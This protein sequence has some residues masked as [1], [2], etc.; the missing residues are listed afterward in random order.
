M[1][2]PAWFCVDRMLLRLPLLLLFVLTLSSHAGEM[3]AQSA[4]PAPASPVVVE[5][6]VPAAPAPGLRQVSARFSAPMVALGSP[7]SP[8]PFDV[9]CPVPGRGR[10]LDDRTWVYDLAAPLPGGIECRFAIRANLTARAG[11]P[12]G[13]NLRFVA[14]SGGPQIAA[15]LP[16][17]GAEAIDESQVFALRTDGAI[18]VESAVS[19]SYCEVDGIAE[20]IPVRLITGAE[21]EEILGQ[22]RALG[23]DYLR[24]LAPDG[25][26][27]ALPPVADRGA[28]EDRLLLFQCQR[29][30]PPGRPM[31]LVWG[32]GIV[33][34]TGVATTSP[35]VFG[36]ATRPAFAATLACQRIN[37]AADCLPLAPIRLEF[38]APVARAVAA[39]V[40]LVP[41]SGGSA[42]PMTLEPAFGEFVDAIEFRAPFAP[43]STLS[44]RLPAGLVDDAG[45]TLSNQDRFPL[46]V[47]L[48]ELPPLASFPSA[49]GIL[50][51]RAEPVLPVTLRNLEPTLDAARLD[52]GVPANAAAVPAERKR[53]DASDADILRWLQRVDEARATRFEPDPAAPDDPARSINATGTRSV[54]GKDDAPERFVLPKPSGAQPLEVVGIPLE[55]PGFYVV[56]L[57]SPQLGAA[58]LGRTATMYVPTAVLVTNL[59]VHFKQGDESALVF[60]TTLDSAAPVADARVRISSCSGQALWSGS[61]DADGIARVPRGALPARDA[62]QWCASTGSALFV[63]A[64]QGEELGF[65]LSSWNRGIAPWDFNL[66]TTPWTG[67]L[68]A[69]TVLDRTLVRAGDT[70]HMKHFLRRQT[71][72]GFEAVSAA[73]APT[74]LVLTHVGSGDTV[75]LPLDLVD[76]VGAGDWRVPP[77]AKLGVYRMS[78]R[79]GDKTLEAGEFRV[80]EF[81]VPTLR[82]TVQPAAT[83]LVDAREAVVDLQL[84]YMNGGPVQGAPVRLRSQ[85]ESRQVAF[86]A[87]EG[88]VFAGGDV[89]EGA[90]DERSWADRYFATA[91]TPSETRARGPARVL[92]LRLDAGG[93]VRATVTGLEPATEPRT[94]VTE[95]EY[96]DANG[97]TL[98]VAA[99]TRLWP[100]RVVLGFA[101]GNWA[102]ARGHVAFRVLAVDTGGTPIANQA[103]SVDLFARETYSYRKRL[104]GGFYAYENST[105][106]RRLPET[107]SGRTDASGVLSCDVL[108]SASGRIVARARA[109]DESGRVAVASH[110]VWVAGRDDW[111]FEAEDSDRMDVLPE[112]PRYE[113]G[114]R[115][116]LQ[117]R[118][119]FREARALVTVEREGVLD[120][121][122]TTLSGA[123]PVVEV[124]IR[125][126][127]GPNVYVS[128][129]ALRGRAA[130]PAPTALVDLGRPAFRLGYA[131]LEVGWQP[132]RLQVQV[133]S[134]QTTYET[135]ATARVHVKVAR[136]DGAPLP[137]GTEFALAAVDEALLELA[138]ND[139]YRLLE[140]MLVPR[141][142]G[143]ITATAQMQVVGK[144]HYGR[145]AEPAG[146]GGGRSAARELFDTLLL[147]RARVPVDAE[148]EADVDVRLNDALSAFRIVAIAHAGT[149]LYGTGAMT[150]RTTAPLSLLAGLPPVVREGDHFVATFTVRNATEAALPVVVQP[151]VLAAQ[152]GAATRTLPVRPAQVTLAPGEGR[153][154]RWDIDVP[155]EAAQLVWTVTATRAGAAPQAVPPG[156]RLRVTQRV[157]P[158]VPVTTQQATVFALDGATTLPVEAPA[159]ALPGRGGLTLAL[160]PR[161]VDSL[162]GLTR[163]MA[164][165]PYSCLEQR[166]S[167][168]VALKD[169]ARWRAIAADLPSYLDNDG[170]LRFFPGTAG[171]GSDVLTAYVLAIASEAGWSLPESVRERTLSALRGIVD[172]A[173][174][175][176]S[177]AA[178]PDLELR[179]IAAIEALSRYGAASPEMLQ[180][181]RIEPALLPTSSLLDLIGILS[182]VN[183]VEQRDARLRAARDLLRARQYAT[184]TVLA[185]ATE[186]DD[187]LWWL[188][189]SPDQNAVRSLLAVL[190]DPARRDQLPALVRGA[191]ARQQG[192]HWDTTL[193]NAWGRLALDRL[194]RTVDASPL[195][196]V[197]RALLAPASS[198]QDWHRAPAGSVLSM[199]W[200]GSTPAAL[201]LSHEGTGRPWVTLASSAAVPLTTSIANGYALRRTL[202]PVVQ[203]TP[204]VHTRGDVLRVTIEVESAADMAWVVV[205]DPVPAGA[206]IIGRGL[207]RDS[208]LLTAGQAEPSLA[209]DFVEPRADVYRA[210]YSFV[211]AGRLR[212]QYTLRLNTAGRLQLPPTRVEAMYAPERYGAAPNAAIEVRS[213]P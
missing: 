35:Q 24:L 65:V 162:D 39:A 70:V 143:V 45:R 75:E 188:L 90:A 167:V 44:L 133:S 161:L 212:V 98:T 20:R 28:L 171:V 174:E 197:T 140:H 178:A 21:R 187:R 194:A 106:T 151:Q 128:V 137:E 134:G 160:R 181:L 199:P 58:L 67:P 177:S 34:P 94:L 159:G 179:R 37:P 195:Q 205:S 144:R 120:A 5:D 42:L 168:A 132:H 189:T 141:G 190:D 38:S 2:Q 86:A 43:A 9:D 204:G 16:A 165:Y 97:E 93:A 169:A 81:R 109:T 69:H 150:L 116:T 148:G 113:P 182:R 173:L 185:F 108:L 112:R 102:I 54:F 25:N 71:L 91:D 80:A 127:Y 23:Y 210:Y 83:D 154:L 184:G 6:F 200:P 136:A 68:V 122:V 66:P 14:S 198:S 125:P 155:A 191:L 146:G 29:Q 126:N 124:P 4:A 107:C 156:D 52:V 13:G 131:R 7:R 158:A 207:Q 170:L 73:A 135:G 79:I 32:T 89:V 138:P 180:T 211:P 33:S 64:R 61:T 27:D 77:S 206:T 208:T 51:S 84:A 74:A 46:E 118:M 101:T 95:L 26:F 59:A 203:A 175:R 149:E 183:G 153:E 166:V 11:A 201:E 40:T 56:E 22:R 30:L 202:E 209:P 142:L 192:G 49:F 85:V 176:A 145:K 119:P 15:A 152:A 121:F 111:W 110:E 157:L 76:G 62:V 10:W 105:Q 196:G 114:E 50:E 139:T 117:V 1:T 72:A 48:D 96:Q 41:G 164:T 104:I 36:Y 129:L 163:Y 100:A 3:P 8:D 123:A 19:G 17:D 55:R 103:V 57:A 92:P 172:G 130:D 147:W 53:I 82:A 18:K 47:K 63:S 87:H 31:R 78:F 186:N 99:R 115:A 193:A 213:A 12:A 60:V 88:Y